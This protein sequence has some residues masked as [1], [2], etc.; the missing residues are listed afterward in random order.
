MT[1]I[2]YSVTVVSKEVIEQGMKLSEKFD[3]VNNMKN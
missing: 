1:F 2:R 3:I